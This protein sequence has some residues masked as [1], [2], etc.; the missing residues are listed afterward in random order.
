[1]VSIT[2]TPPPPY[3]VGDVLTCSSDGFLPTYEWFDSLA[4]GA[5]PIGTTNKLT[6]DEAG[7]IIRLCRAT[8]TGPDLMPCEADSTT[9][10]DTVLSTRKYP[11]PVPD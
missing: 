5:M 11:T 1:M 7:H 2:P 6:L 8:A 4:A 10:V 3:K 9:I